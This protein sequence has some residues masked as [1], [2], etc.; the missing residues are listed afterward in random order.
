M[1]ELVEREH[2]GALQIGDQPDAPAK[3]EGEDQPIPD[4]QEHARQGLRQGEEAH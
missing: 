1:H 2:F 3:E 4:E